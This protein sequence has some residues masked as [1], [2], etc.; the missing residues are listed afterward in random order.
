VQKEIVEARDQ[1]SATSSAANN[2]LRALELNKNAYAGLMAGTRGWLK[3][4][5]EDESEGGPGTATEELD[6]IIKSSTL[7][8]LKAIFGGMPTEGE[9]K[10]LMEIQGSSDK[11]P[12][13]RKEIFRRAYAMA[14]AR[15]DYNQ[16]KAHA[17]IDGTYFTEGFSDEPPPL[18]A[19][20]GLAD[21]K[22]K[23]LGVMRK[24]FRTKDGSM[25][26]G[27]S[28]DGGKTWEPE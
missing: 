9:R 11:A 2:F 12:Q 26:W 25:Q 17:M 20:L 3:S 28:K 21:E 16:A 15:K 13:V 24:Q 8:N 14:L 19:Y 18:E 23:G 5:T 4:L 1:I 10:V 22:I 6:N 27:V 7:D